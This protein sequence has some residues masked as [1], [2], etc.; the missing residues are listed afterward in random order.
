[1]CV[2]LENK[3]KRALQLL[4]DGLDKVG[5]GDG[6]LGRSL[7]RVVQVLCELCY[8]FRVSIGLKEV[9]LFF[10]NS[11][12]FLVIG[13]DACSGKQPAVVNFFFT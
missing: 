10:K 9:S 7:L 6:G 12:Q 3:G 8:A 2:A 11:T 5:E 13:D 4:D 1:M